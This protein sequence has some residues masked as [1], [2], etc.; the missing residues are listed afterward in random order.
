MKFLSFALFVCVIAACEKSPEGPKGCIGNEQ[1]TILAYRPHSDTSKQLTIEI[2]A[3]VEHCPHTAIV[4]FDDWPHDTDSKPIEYG[5]VIHRRPLPVIG[6]DP[7]GEN[8]EMG[9][10][11]TSGLASLNCCPCEYR[12]SPPK[13]I[14]DLLSQCKRDLNEQASLCKSRVDECESKLSKANGEVETLETERRDIFG[15]VAGSFIKL[16]NCKK[17]LDHL[18]VTD[19]TTIGMFIDPGNNKPKDEFKRVVID[20]K[21]YMKQARR[22]Q[23]RIKKLEEVG[24]MLL[25]THPWLNED[26][27][28]QRWSNVNAQGV[29]D[30]YEGHES[31]CQPIQ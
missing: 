19:E 10:L 28:V 13:G 7:R 24:N 17:Q 3:E 30:Y 23:T 4:S 21:H 18:N 16:E 14:D 15:E 11:S 5:I 2:P 29:E 20:L 6:N 1:V 27:G 9:R 31:E 22:I 26:A 8:G 12:L 25:K